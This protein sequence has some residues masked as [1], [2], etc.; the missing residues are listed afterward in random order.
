[1][2]TNKDASIVIIG[3]GCAGITS[4]RYLEDAG[5]TNITIL[6]KSAFLGGCCKSLHYDDYPDVYEMGAIEVGKIGY[7]HITAFL[8]EF[9]LS[10][11]D[12]PSVELMDPEHGNPDLWKPDSFK[13]SSLSILERIRYYEEI[14][15]YGL[16]L[17]EHLDLVKPGFN[18]LPDSICIS[19]AEWC[20]QHDIKFLQ[21]A[22]FSLITAY[23]YGYLGF[24][25]DDLIPLPYVMKYL[26]P[27][28]LLP[29]LSAK[30]LIDEIDHHL[31]D[32]VAAGLGALTRGEGNMLTRIKDVG[33]QGLMDRIAKALK[34]TTIKTSAQIT[35]IKRT[36]ESVQLSYTQG[37]VTTEAQFDKMIISFHQNLDNLEKCGLDVREDESDL[38]KNVK[39]RNYYTMT[40]PVSAFA[41]NSHV[42]EENLHYSDI[43][44]EPV[45]NLCPKCDFPFQFF[46][47]ANKQNPDDKAMAVF[48]S[49]AKESVTVD[50]IKDNLVK[51]LKEMVNEDIQVTD[52]REGIGWQYFAHVDACHLKE[53]WYDKVNA[54]QGKNNT[55]WAGSLF[56]FELT[57]RTAAFSDYLVKT[58]F[59]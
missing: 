24:D 39:F 23:G 15:L 5:Y 12:M 55:Y 50:Q 8:D 59:T 3:A 30:G 44:K 20:K 25:E 47:P 17:V 33:F 18:K 1:M 22:F 14:V 28:E 43:A 9:G 4:A 31:P 38:F 49:Y 41:K 29:R 19:F 46:I 13:T 53:G 45:L 26:G 10:C 32:L 2:G 56:N 57:E 42:Y 11:E 27:T 7:D 54:I 34:H 37:G 52:I 6:E 35:S 51:N 36:T 21:R 48:Y 58:Y 40:V 16:L